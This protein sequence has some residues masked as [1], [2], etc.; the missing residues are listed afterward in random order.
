MKLGFAFLFLTCALLFPQ[1][2]P[3]SPEDV[4]KCH[5]ACDKQVAASLAGCQKAAKTDAQKKN[6][7]AQ[8]QQLAA[9]CSKSCP[10]LPQ[11]P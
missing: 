4:I 11:K 9:F 1:G 2:K 5:Q 6:C 8:A 3:P 7:E 10:S